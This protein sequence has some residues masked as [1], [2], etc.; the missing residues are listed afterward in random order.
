MTKFVTFVIL[1]LSG[2]ELWLLKKGQWVFL[3]IPWFFLLVE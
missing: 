3:L 2:L 1:I